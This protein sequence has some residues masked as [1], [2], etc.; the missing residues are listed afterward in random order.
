[1]EKIT[2]TTTETQ[3]IGQDL[4]RTL[5]SGTIICLQ[6][7]LGAGKTTLVQGIA[8]GLGIEGEITSPTFTLMNTYSATSPG[9]TIHTLV[10]ID[11]YRLKNAEELIA[12]GAEDYL[13]APGVATII[14]WPEKIID[15]LKDKKVTSVTLEH[16]SGDQR[17]ITI[18]DGK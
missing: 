12:I 11:T 3:K 15:L 13:G 4:A 14:E 2:T 18:K 10:H 1:M 16:L 6:G 7:E 17:K 9:T 5:T 8:E